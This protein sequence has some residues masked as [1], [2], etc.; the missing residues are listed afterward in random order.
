MQNTEL[1]IQQGYPIDFQT[2]FDMQ[3][4]SNNHRSKIFYDDYLNQSLAA[5]ANALKLLNYVTDLRTSYNNLHSLEKRAT[6]M[7]F[8][9]YRL[10]LR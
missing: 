7:N 3:F 5:S 6:P 8:A 10:V 9:K 4:I 2:C 1:L